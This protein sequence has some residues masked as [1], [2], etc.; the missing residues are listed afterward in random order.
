MQS[1][2]ISLE[3]A[4]PNGYARRRVL[5]VSSHVVQYGSP[6]Y[7]AMSNNPCLDVEVAYC[8]MLGAEPGMDADF[9]QTIQWDVPLLD[10]YRWVL[11]P[12][13]AWQPGIGRFFGLINTG[14]WRKIRKGH[15]DAVVIYTGYRYATFWITLAAAKLSGT[16]LIFGTDATGL[17]PRTDQ[18]WRAALKKYLLPRVFKLATIVIPASTAGVDFIR[19]LGIPPSRIV[20]FPFVVDNDWWRRRAAQV[21]RAA[22]RK[23]WDIPD[24]AFVAL[25]CGKLQPWKRPMDALRAFAKARAPN[26]YLVFAGDGA[27]RD[28][29]VCEVAKLGL[30]GRVRML[31]FQNQS[32]LPAVYV[33]CDLLVF[34]SE[35]EPFGVVVNEAMLCGCAV[36]VSDRVGARR[37]LVRQDTGF[38]FPCGD[39][40]ALAKIV[41]LAVAEPDRLH[42]MKRASTALINTWSPREYVQSLTA[43]LDRIYGARSGAE[44]GSET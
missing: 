27:M 23:S 8:S 28:D 12:N 41:R 6:V 16:P 43:A 13:R 38:V 33:G 17:K 2:R 7:R 26:S 40:E 11:V 15:Y 21:D 30:Q 35:Y 36:A 9:G 25:F 42:Q 14:L 22:T 1:R 10:G 34:S 24:D 31:G 19:S 44:D 18:R 3:S 29:L 5:L 37:D 32:R 39:L 20:M 4:S